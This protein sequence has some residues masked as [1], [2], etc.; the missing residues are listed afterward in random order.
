[1][2]VGLMQVR[3]P[4]PELQVPSGW[5]RDCRRLAILAVWLALVYRSDGAN[6]AEKGSPFTNVRCGSGV[7]QQTPVAEGI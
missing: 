3:V 5:V 1:M 2:G 7:C 6:P 4:K